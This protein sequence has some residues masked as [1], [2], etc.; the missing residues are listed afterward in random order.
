VQIEVQAACIRSL[1]Y[2]RPAGAQGAPRNTLRR[3]EATARATTPHPLACF[4]KKGEVSPRLFHH[5]L[6]SEHGCSSSVAARSVTDTARRVLI[7]AL[8]VMAPYL[9]KKLIFLAS[10]CQNSCRFTDL[11]L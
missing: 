9:L 8:M 2:Q 3:D 5:A 4:I 10:F 11:G 6:N 1:A 7:G